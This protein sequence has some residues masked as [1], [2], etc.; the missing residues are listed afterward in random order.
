[1]FIEVA[2]PFPVLA[3]LVRCTLLSL[4]LV[5][6]T[7]ALAQAPPYA[8]AVGIGTTTEGVIGTEDRHPSEVRQLAVDAAG[9]TYVTGSFE[10][11]V[12]FGPSTLVS[13]G[14][15][16]LF[17]VKLDAA[18]HT[19]WALRAGDRAADSG[20]GVTVDKAGNVYLT[21][22]FRYTATFGSI[23]LTG[24]GTSVGFV[25][26]FSSEGACQ[27]ALPLVE[28]GGYGTSVALDSDDNLL[29]AGTYS[30][31]AAQFGNTTLLNVGSTEN[32]FVAKLTHAGA[33]RWASRAGTRAG[34]VVVDDSGNVY[35]TGNFGLTDTFGPLTLTAHGL[36]DGYIAKLDAAGSWQWV[37]S[38]GGPGYDYAAGVD[39]DYAGNVWIAGGFGQP[40]ATFGT[41]TLA[42]AGASDFDA[43]VAKL[44]TDGT[45]L[46]AVRAGGKGNDLANSLVVDDDGTA[47]VVGQYEDEGA[48]FAPLQMPNLG[49]RL[50]QAYVSKLSAQGAFTWVA[51]TNGTYS[52]FGQSIALDR[53]GGV[54]AGGFFTGRS[55]TFGS[56]TLLQ[57][58][59]ASTGFV[60]KI[61]DSPL[62][63]A[64]ALFPA[65]GAAGTEV[66][67]RGARLAGATAVYFDG[68]PASSFTQLS[69][70]LLTAIAPAQV[71]TGPVTV[72]TAAG[73]DAV[74]SLFQVGT[75]TATTGVRKATG[76]W[77]NPAARG[78]RVQVI[79]PTT[80]L[81]E[82]ALYTLLGQPVFTRLLDPALSAI[83]LGTVASG[84]YVLVLRAPGQLPL[85]YPLQ[86]E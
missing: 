36:Q 53:R 67:I 47:Y 22:Y 83:E 80:G 55:I 63:R 25:A 18:G 40:S 62:P 50:G 6:S 33:W 64:A 82:V 51:T 8:W 9:N 66:A 13:A 12:D 73:T 34:N 85:R 21:G 81:M 74:G 43:Y 19:L 10:R 44:S 86:V 70:T 49:R 72:E 38:A 45:Y 5:Y 28:Q 46:W 29:V 54:Y 56:T 1:M 15:R 7:A 39:V 37:R 58:P 17:L 26:K 65:Q 35:L 16:D 84:S 20:M 2:L 61:G 14:G 79:A 27:W 60:A 32:G 68:V 77:P 71:R 11:S 52:E 78:G 41:T 24:P 23:T 42:N 4:L 69:P 3:R 57:N 59:D 76:C 30:S 31:S 48:T 75:L